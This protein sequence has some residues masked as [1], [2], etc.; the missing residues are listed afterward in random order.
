MKDFQPDSRPR[1]KHPRRFLSLILTVA[2]HVGLLVFLFVGIDWRS[3]PLGSLE[4]GLVG[5]PPSAPP[6]PAPPDPQPPQDKTEPV[7][8]PPKEPPKPEPPKPEPPKPEPP[9]PEPPKREDPK[10]EIAT[11]KQEKPE[12]P[13]PDP[14]PKTEPKLAPLNTPNLQNKLDA[15]IERN[16][17]AKK[18]DSL[19]NAGQGGRASR[20]ELD[21]YRTAIATKVRRN[22]IAPPGL[23]GNPVALFE[24]EQIPGSNGGEVI[25]VQL[26]QSSGNRALDTAIERAIWK[27]SPLPPPANPGLFDRKLKVD[28]R[29]LEE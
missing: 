19:L 20:E 10:P 23:S 5:A 8:E 21:A 27:S 4:V 26:V 28:F 3:K 9:K 29:P 18:A 25:S 15:A 14:K 13:K 11:K 7:P 16:A 22:L 24:I 6:T 12:K 1:E 2:V 17:E